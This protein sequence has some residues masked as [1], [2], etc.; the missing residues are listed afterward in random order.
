[1][2]NTSDTRVWQVVVTTTNSEEEANRLAAGVVQER[3]AACAQVDGPITSTYWWEGSAANDPEWHLT[4]KTSAAKY[5]ELER[6]LL[7]THSY[8]VP[9][10]I[11]ATP[12]V[13]GHDKYI[14]WVRDET[15]TSE[16]KA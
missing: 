6:Y 13:A 4:I 3:L 2:S 7:K 10:E 9:A 1:M 11:L 15:A 12:V 14:Q 16:T 5:D 8:E